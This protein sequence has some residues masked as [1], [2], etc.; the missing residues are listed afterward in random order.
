MYNMIAELERLISVPEC[1]KERFFTEII[2][3]RQIQPFVK[4]LKGQRHCM[5]RR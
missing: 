3:Q 5:F 2:Y 1:K 4:K